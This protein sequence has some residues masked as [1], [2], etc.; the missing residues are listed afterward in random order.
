MTN[1]MQLS[2]IEENTAIQGLVSHQGV[3]MLAI[4][5]MINKRGKVY[6]G[7]KR[8][9]QS[10]I[11]RLGIQEHWRRSYAFDDQ[12]NGQEIYVE[13]C[14]EGESGDFLWIDAITAVERSLSMGLLPSKAHIY[15]HLGSIVVHPP[16][17]FEINYGQKKAKEL[18]LSGFSIKDF[19]L[20]ATEREQRK[21]KPTDVGC[22][23]YLVPNISM[24]ELASSTIALAGD[25]TGLGFAE[26]TTKLKEAQRL[27][28]EL[29]A[30]SNATGVIKKEGGKNG[31]NYER[32][33]PSG[34]SP[35]WWAV[36]RATVAA[37][38]FAF[39]AMSDQ[40]IAVM[41]HSEGHGASFDDAELMAD[42]PL[43]MPENV[44]PEYLNLKQSN[45]TRIIPKLSQEERVELMRG[46]D[47]DG[48]D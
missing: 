3:Q 15:Y 29:V 17:T 35:E 44:E 28:C 18:G 8:V 39:G 36:K 19:P 13:R 31:D 23:V 26:R 20:T 1:K 25:L 2:T 7:Y 11:D 33:T 37:I 9:L 22:I 14:A 43:S 48:I 41:A 46:P 21:L 38:R 24:G 10:T 42:M 30:M 40:E 45:A 5:L 12:G 16:Y 4:R 27:A 34:R 32:R 6:E 47:E